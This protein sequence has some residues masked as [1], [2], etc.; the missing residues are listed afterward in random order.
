MGNQAQY[1]ESIIF[2]TFLVHITS[3]AKRVWINQWSDLDEKEVSVLKN[4]Y[5][6]L[7]VLRRSKL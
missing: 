2:N 4:V 7:S 3:V 6:L 5:S 1:H